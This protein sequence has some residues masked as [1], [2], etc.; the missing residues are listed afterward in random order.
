[1]FVPSLIGI[2]LIL[3]SQWCLRI[4]S[5]FWYSKTSLDER[6]FW[7]MSQIIVFSL[8]KSQRPQLMNSIRMMSLKS[9]HESTELLQR[10]RDRWVKLHEWAIENLR[11][12]LRR[13]LTNWILWVLTALD[14]TI[15]RT[16]ES[17]LW[18]WQD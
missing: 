2:T 4:N 12:L 13:R 17:K 8:K 7:W 11:A 5:G 10:W 1:M 16:S 18:N 6:K 3:F 14:L 9:G 15:F